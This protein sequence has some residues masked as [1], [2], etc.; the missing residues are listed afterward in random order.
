MFFFSKEVLAA[1]EVP[2]QWHLSAGVSHGIDPEA[3]RHGGLFLMQAFGLA[4]H[5]PRAALSAV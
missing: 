2:C 1:A 4:P 5:Q 3:L